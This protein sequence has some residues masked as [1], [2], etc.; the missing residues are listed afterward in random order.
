MYNIQD[1]LQQGIR[2]AIKK[3]LQTKIALSMGKIA[4]QSSPSNIFVIYL[5]GQAIKP[6]EKP[7]YPDLLGASVIYPVS[8]DIL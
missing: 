5:L 4:I 6:S 1:I 3:L 2:K 7:V 8:L